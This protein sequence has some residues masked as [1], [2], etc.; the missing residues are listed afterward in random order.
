M[1]FAS[2][3]EP[4]NPIAFLNAIAENEDKEEKELT[5]PQ[6]KFLFTTAIIAKGRFPIIIITKA[7]PFPNW[8]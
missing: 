7:A 2:G 8:L 6:L 1:F 3:Y 4:G 5:F